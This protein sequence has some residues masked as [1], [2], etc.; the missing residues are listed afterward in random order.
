MSRKLDKIKISKST[1]IDKSAKVTA[2]QLLHMFAIIS[3]HKITPIHK[4]QKWDRSAT[5]MAFSCDMAFCS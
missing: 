2:H 4:Q 1:D 3:R 5:A